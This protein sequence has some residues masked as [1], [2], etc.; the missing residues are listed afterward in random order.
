MKQEREISKIK[1]MGAEL[2]GIATSI[3]ALMTLFCQKV[4]QF[5]SGDDCAMELPAREY[6]SIFRCDQ[7]LL[8]S[9]IQQEIELKRKNLN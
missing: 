5:R 7:E 2:Q 6:Q 9:L 1:A 8:S 4:D 3:E